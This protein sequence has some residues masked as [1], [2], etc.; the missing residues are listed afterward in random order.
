MRLAEEVRKFSSA[1]EHLLAAAATSGRTLT[2]D[3]TRVVEYYC[4][5][6]LAKSYRLP[7]TRHRF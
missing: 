2:A 7:P 3:E 5:E 1:C 4:K 6:V